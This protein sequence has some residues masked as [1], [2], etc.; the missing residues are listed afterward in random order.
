MDGWFNKE[1]VKD[2]VKFGSTALFIDKMS[3]RYSVG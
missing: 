2:D 1:S 3:A